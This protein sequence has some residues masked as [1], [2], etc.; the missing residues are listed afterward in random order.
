MRV[1]IHVCVCVCVCVCFSVH[2]C[3]Y[4]CVCPSMCVC[5]CVYNTRNLDIAVHIRSPISHTLP[6]ALLCFWY[7]QSLDSLS[8]TLQCW[9][10]RLFH[11]QFPYL[12]HLYV[13][14]PSPSCLKE[15]LSGLLQIQP[16]NLSF[17]SQNSRPVIFSPV[18]L[19]SPFIIRF[20]SCLS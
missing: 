9:F 10:P 2:V 14:W 15:T 16:Q 8:Q 3:L 12:Q 4:A 18:A 13:E 7:S 1:S 17:F 19:L 5:V 11:C 6:Y 20:T